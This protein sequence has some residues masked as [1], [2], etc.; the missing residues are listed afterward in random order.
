MSLD[1][2]LYMGSTDEVIK[3]LEEQGCKTEEGARMM[4]RGAAQSNVMGVMSLGGGSLA[5]TANAS[6]KVLEHF[7][8]VEEAAKEE[9]NNVED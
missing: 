8:K 7:R 4:L 6:K 9:E 1:L 2:F 5:G 3:I